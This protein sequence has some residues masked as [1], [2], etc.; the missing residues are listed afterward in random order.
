MSAVPR[1]NTRSRYSSVVSPNNAPLSHC[2]NLL[3][4]GTS[5][6]DIREVHRDA[7]SVDIPTEPNPQPS[8]HDPPEDTTHDDASNR[9]P[10][11]YAALYDTPT[12]LERSFHT[13]TRSAHNSPPPLLPRF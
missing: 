3:F 7:S 9:H 10:P 11:N 8:R 5:S 12:T 1:R 4:P 13:V 2:R 6:D